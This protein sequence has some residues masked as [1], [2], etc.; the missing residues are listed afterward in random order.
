M[1]NN[2]PVAIIGGYD[3]IAKSFYSKLKLL[4]KNSI[5]INLQDKKI[6]R[7]GVYNLEIFQ[8][9]KIL[10][11][12]KNHNIKNLLFLGKIERPNI[13]KFKND[14]E[15]EKYIPNLIASYKK[16][17]GNILL[18][19]VNIFANKGYNI[20]SPTK[21]SESFFLNNSNIHV[22][23]SSDDRIDINKSRK[24]LNDL[25]KYDNAQS[26]VSI[27]GYVIA[28]EAA[29]GTDKLLSRVTVIRKKLNQHENKAGILTKIPKLGQSKLIDLPVLGVK[30]LKLVSKANLNG[31][32][33]NPKLTIIHN[34]VNFLKYAKDFNLKIY[35]IL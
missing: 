15:I 28:I 1:K 6:V 29:E 4:N 34:K 33:I 18:S 3:L 21:I 31:I 23:I 17:D 22:P 19:V 5:F 26:V 7:K 25:S 32:A 30:T 20:L 10:E 27:N 14:G 8:L 9:K 13:S 35:S 16:G 24:L 11:T 12:L 2:H